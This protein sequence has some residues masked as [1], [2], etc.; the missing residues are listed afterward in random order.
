MKNTIIT[1]TALM[2]FIV[3]T[4]VS[5]SQTPPEGK[6]GLTA[7]DREMPPQNF[8]ERKAWILKRIDDRMKK[9]Q[10]EK[11]CVEAAKNIDDLNKCRPARPEGP[12]QRNPQQQP[13]K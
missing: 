13:V 12:G 1:A 11:A 2:I 4:G 6:P 10:A 3:F 9:T 5:F 8:D 7:G